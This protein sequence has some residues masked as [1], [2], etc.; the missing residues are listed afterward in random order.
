MRTVVDL[1]PDVEEL[2]RRQARDRDLEFDHVL[3]DA[4]RAGLLSRGTNNDRRVAQKGY[5]LGSEGVD[6]TKALALSDDPEDEERL[7]KMREAEQE[8]R[9]KTLLSLEGSLSRKEGEELRTTTK[10]LRESW[11]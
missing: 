9:R 1:D 4:I 8:E 5:P 2:L 11:R 10:E 3:N 6:L 7:R